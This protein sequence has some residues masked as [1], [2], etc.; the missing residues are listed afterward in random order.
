MAVVRELL[1]APERLAQMAAR[2]HGL[3]TPGAADRLV[4]LI[5]ALA[6]R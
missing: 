5:L 4:D 6:R 3:A 2:A 1:G